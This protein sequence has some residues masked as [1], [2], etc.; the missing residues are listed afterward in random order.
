MSS[1]IN[2]LQLYTA[3]ELREMLTR[4]GFKILDQFGIN[5]S[6]FSEKNTERVLTIA[7]KSKLRIFHKVIINVLEFR[8]RQPK[9]NNFKRAK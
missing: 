5:G 8:D 6:K 1:C 2:T 7:K 4:N 3:R 9:C